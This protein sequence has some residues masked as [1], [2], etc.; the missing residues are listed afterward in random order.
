MNHVAKAPITYRFDGEHAFEYRFYCEDCVVPQG[1]EVFNDYRWEPLNGVAVAVYVCGPGMWYLPATWPV[2]SRCL[3]YPLAQQGELGS[4]SMQSMQRSLKFG[5][6]G[7]YVMQLGCRYP[8]QDDA[9]L[10]YGFVDAGFV[11]PPHV[12]TP[13]ADCTAQNE[14]LVL[15][16]E[17]VERGIAAQPNTM[18]EAIDVVRLC[19]HKRHPALR[20]A[21]EASHG[22]SACHCCCCCCWCW[23][24]FE[25]TMCTGWVVLV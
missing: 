9:L 20:F 19:A 23:A 7:N 17:K 22:P 21:V 6:Q 10:Y 4:A 12:I 16:L 25:V 8:D 3:Q 15:A 18:E 1:A 13:T 5:F 24:L 14:A 11:E 2:A